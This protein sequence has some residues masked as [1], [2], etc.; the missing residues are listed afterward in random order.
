MGSAVVAGLDGSTPSLRFSGTFA[1]GALPLSVLGL[2]EAPAR[3]RDAFG[4]GLSAPALDRARLIANRPEGGRSVPPHGLTGTRPPADLGPG[5]PGREL[6][7]YP[8]FD[9]LA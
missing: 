7:V 5:Q 3:R 9:R 6:P 1:L 2:G 8:A 4:P